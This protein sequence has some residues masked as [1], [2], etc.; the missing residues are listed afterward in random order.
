MRTLALLAAILLLALQ[1][2]TEPLRET[3][4]EV[5]DQ[6]EPGAEDQDVA[7][8]FDEDKLSALDDSK[9]QGVPLENIV[10]GFAAIIVFA[11]YVAAAEK[12]SVH[13]LHE[14]SV[15]PLVP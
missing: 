4:D 2:Q 9:D 10:V 13:N 11:E 14:K 12:N 8:S 15:K 3:N 7:V 5:T 6:E 1:A